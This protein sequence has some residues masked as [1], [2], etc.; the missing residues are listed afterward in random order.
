MTNKAQ[1]L[2]GRIIESYMCAAG[3]PYTEIFNKCPELKE[4][5]DITKT[6]IN[7]ATQ[8]STKEKMFRSLRKTLKSRKKE[9]IRD[10]NIKDRI[11]PEKTANNDPRRGGNRIHNRQVA[12]SLIFIRDNITNHG[13]KLRKAVKEFKHV[14]ILSDIVR[15]LIVTRLGGWREKDGQYENHDGSVAQKKNWQL[16]NDGRLRP[17]GH[18]PTKYDIGWLIEV[19]NYCG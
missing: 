9:H 8:K 14:D 4:L 10:I 3:E 1:V 5:Y 12:E 17:H 15:Q 7:E 16:M 13:D 19:G 6:E 18:K 2:L 11:R